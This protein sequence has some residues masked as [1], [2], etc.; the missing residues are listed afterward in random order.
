MDRYSRQ[1]VFPRVGEDGQRRLLGATALVLGCGALGSCAAELL[2][3]AGV[4]TLRLVDR[5]YLE[6]HNL[7][8]QSLYDE[9]ALA[10]DL[11]KAE[12]AARRVREINSGLTVDPRVVDVTADNVLDLLEGVDVVL[13]GTD[14]WET[15]YLLN[16]ASV[17]TGVPWVYGAVLGV[18][19]MSMPILPGTT[20]CLRCVFS[21]PPP[22]GGDTC[23]TAGVLGPAVWIVSSVQAMW[24][25]RILLG[26]PPSAGLTTVDA[27]SGTMESVALGRPEPDCP[28]CGRRELRFLFGGRPLSTRLCGRD[29]VQV[30]AP[31]GADLDLASAAERLRAVGAVRHN[32]HLLKL[33]IDGYELTLFADGRAVVKGTTEEGVA[34]SLYAR[35]IGS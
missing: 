29:A 25:L 4:G 12:A 3:R 31:P 18:S 35:Y 34:R 20:P 19:G 32:E 16:D 6:A 30:S 9:R 8:R 33:A 15:R 24:A 10:L 23:E 21:E 11:P 22:P 28:A 17:S 5:D 13:D 2:A 27:W 7:Q 14:N 1:T 26:D